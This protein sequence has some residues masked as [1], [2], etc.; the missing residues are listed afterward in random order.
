MDIT[1]TRSMVAAALSG[2]LDRAEC[3]PDPVFKVL[4][5]RTCPGVPDA[6]V[7]H[8]VNTWADRDAYAAKAA[9][10][11]SE[12]AAFF[13]KNYEGKVDASVARECPGL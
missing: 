8:P 5:P 12:F 3:D 9:Q 1:L 4:I 11:A 7:L 2:E 13:R 10:L 6:S